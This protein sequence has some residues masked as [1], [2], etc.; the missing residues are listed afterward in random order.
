M[1]VTRRAARTRQTPV[2]ET[3]TTPE[4]EPPQE[5]I[6]PTRDDRQMSEQQAL[7]MLRNITDDLRG[8]NDIPNQ[9][10]NIYGRLNN[11]QQQVGDLQQDSREQ[12]SIPSHIGGSGDGGSDGSD[13]GT[14]SFSSAAR[15]NANRRIQRRNPAGGGGG[16]SNPSSS[17]SRSSRSRSTQSSTTNP[18]SASTGSSAMTDLEFLLDSCG[19][20]ADEIAAIHNHGYNTVRQF[21]EDLYNEKKIKELL[22]SA[23][24]NSVANRVF[25]VQFKVEQNLYGLAYW[26][27][28]HYR[29]GIEPPIDEFDERALHYAKR[30]NEATKGKEDQVD[31]MPKFGTDAE[32]YTWKDGFVNKL[33]SMESMMGKSFDLA[34][35]IRDRT[36]TVEK[37]AEGFRPIDYQIRMGGPEF[38]VD[39]RRVAHVLQEEV[40]N[41]EGAYACTQD[42]LRDEDGRG[43][44][45]ALMKEYD[46]ETAINSRVIRAEQDFGKLHYNGNE[47]VF[48]HRR[49]CERFKKNVRIMAKQPDTMMAPR[50]VRN[51]YFAKMQLPESMTE[52]KTIVYNCKNDRS[53]TLDECMTRIQDCITENVPTSVNPKKR[54]HDNR[55]LSE[56]KRKEGLKYDPTKAYDKIEGVNVNFD[57]KI[58]FHLY[59]KLSNDAKTYF[60]LRRIHLGINKGNENKKV[61]F[62]KDIKELRVSI[63]ELEKKQARQEDTPEDR[64]G[65]DNNNGQRGS[66]NGDRF[67]QS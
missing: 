27:H 9:I 10:A 18:A 3:V 65:N 50:I 15:Q 38:K 33:R 19:C 20:S 54:K 64:S 25:S 59:R 13:S 45:L 29:R 24:N 63:S 4:Q 23:K 58:P 28:D 1:V 11:L 57:K 60:R 39:N 66:R 34:Y 35:V 62:E 30:D 49:F 22:K 43:A 47:A 26:L 42:H 46:G 7:A 32:F 52:I 44:F 48:S 17:N 40:Q 21:S 8:L 61:R 51:H 6:Q 55:R 53:M 67:G 5:P 31:K 16:D 56:F 2:V 37:P 36:G 14:D 41:H 12:R